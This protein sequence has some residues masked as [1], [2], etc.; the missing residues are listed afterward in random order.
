MSRASD[1]TMSVP[2]QFAFRAGLFKPIPR[3][4]GLGILLRG[5]TEGVPVRDLIG[6]SDG[7]RRPGYII[8]VEPGISYMLSNFTTTL[9]VPVA[10]I[11][12]RTRSLNDIA[13]SKPKNIKHGDAGLLL[14]T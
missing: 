5:R 11:R 4:H 14:I 9:T 1:S 10:L 7:F 8:S 6:G 2:D 3:L 12:N 13:D